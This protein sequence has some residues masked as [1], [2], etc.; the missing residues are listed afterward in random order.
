MKKLLIA[1]LIVG[2]AVIAALSFGG[3]KLLADPIQIPEKTDSPSWLP[4]SAGSTASDQPEEETPYV[5]T[6]TDYAAIYAL[7]D[8][9]EVVMTIDGREITWQDYFYA[10]YGQASSLEQDFQMYQYYGYAL[11]WESQADAEGHTYAEIVGDMCLQNL[12]RIITAEAVAEENGVSLL[13]EE[14][15]AVQDEHQETI[16]YFCGE[17]GTEEELLRFLEEERYLRPELYWRI[18]RF[19]A[20]TQA[21][22]R[23][24]YGSEGENLSDQQVVD[25][26]AEQG[27]LSA[28]HILIST[29]DPETYQPMGEEAVAEKEALALQ[30]AAELQAI[31]DPEARE[32]R[33]QELKAEY[34]EDPDAAEG[35]VFAPDIMVP[36]FYDGT[37]ALEEGQISDP[38]RTDYGFHIV[39]RR[40]LRAE[41]TIITASG[42]LD[43]RSLMV[44]T[45]FN[46]LMQERYDAQVVEFAPGFEVPNV[47]DYQISVTA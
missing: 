42:E 7:H 40:P 37:L 27:V 15:A 30:I 8:P 36:E 46:Q 22:S 11:G 26:M 14:E 16:V 32:A 45:L 6:E 12:R 1:L 28:D 33:F 44:Q 34:G 41:D 21:V 35:Y 29:I 39:L 9:D 24:L 47:L 10:F 3:D 4:A 5:Y 25:W 18:M 13:P 31:E 43:A 38:I 20:T 2:L 19:S 17:D 23:T